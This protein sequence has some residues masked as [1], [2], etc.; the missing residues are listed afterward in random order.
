MVCRLP[1][2]LEWEKAARGVDGRGYVWGNSYEPGRALL[3][4]HPERAL[5]PV[6]APPG[7][8]PRD[9]SVYG[10]R[11]LTGNVRELIR[12]PGEKGKLFMV[13]GGSYA[14]APQQANTANMYYVN[15]GAGDL[16]FRYVLEIPAVREKV[17]PDTPGAGQ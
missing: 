15:G 11:D 7:T 1:T 16:G 8:C 4:D 14:T 3:R 10:V 13:I 9:I 5:Y 17:E 12:S 2:R 6:G